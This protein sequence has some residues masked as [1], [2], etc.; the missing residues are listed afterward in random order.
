MTPF[1]P[2]PWVSRPPAQAAI[3]L[4]SLLKSHHLLAAHRYSF[5]P[6][7]DR[8]HGSVYRPSSRTF[9][10]SRSPCPACSWLAGPPAAGERK[11]AWRKGGGRQIELAPH[12]KAGRK[13]H[14]WAGTA[15]RTDATHVISR[16]DARGRCRLQGELAKRL[17]VKSYRPVKMLEDVATRTNPDLWIAGTMAGGSSQ[18]FPGTAALRNP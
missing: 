2:R 3:P 5:R 18:G 9:P 4:I 15:R 11:R 10:A 7:P 17:A 13:I 16:R 8:D 12:M 1:L 6:P 14:V